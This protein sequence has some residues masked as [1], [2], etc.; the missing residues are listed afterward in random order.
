MSWPPATHQD[1]QDAVTV[2]RNAAA[3]AFHYGAAGNGT[4]DDT[5]A[6]QAAINSLPEGGGTVV[7]PRGTF[8]VTSPLV[9]A[10]G[11]RFLGAGMLATTVDYSG[12]SS[13]TYCFQHNMGIGDQWPGRVVFEDFTIQGNATGSLGVGATV[14]GIDCSDSNAGTLVN[15]PFYSLRRVRLLNL[16][17]GI[18]LEGY[19]HHF[20][21]CVVYQCATGYDL[22]HPEQSMLLNCWADFCGTGVTVNTHKQQYGHSF[23]IIG[24]AYQ[25]CTTGIQLWNLYEPKIE[26]Y[27]QSNTAADVICGDSA[28]TTYAKS[29]KGLKLDAS[30]ASAPSTA[31]IVLY[32]SVDAQIKF[33]SRYGSSFSAPHVLAN[34]YTKWLDVAYDSEAVESTNPWSFAG[35]SVLRAWAH[36][37]GGFEKPQTPTL[38]T[39]YT[40][41]ASLPFRFFKTS[42]NS[43]KIQ[44]GVNVGASPGGTVFTLPLGYRP[45]VSQIFRVAA[46]A[47]GW[48]SGHTI[49]VNTDGTVNFSDVAGSRELFFDADVHLGIQV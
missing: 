4:T 47:G 32:G 38:A 14:N 25:N 28:D 21:E 6:I 5:T 24:G 16:A 13:G 34:G 11:V 26:T 20:E 23:H 39:G 37:T 17:T 45:Q 44:G 36:P 49:Q 35:D 2:L 15:T 22:T 30:F 43:L 41:D 42:M 46:Y 7:L 12:G 40:A 9:Y 31:N 29:V 33:R 3:N 1:V 27:F 18:Q 19:G 8:K 48:T 10:R